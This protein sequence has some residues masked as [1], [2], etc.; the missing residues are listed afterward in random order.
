M[1]KKDYELIAEI[2]ADYEPLYIKEEE[3]KT[4]LVKQLAIAFK[5]DNPKFKKEL[6]LKACKIR[7]QE[8]K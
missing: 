8:T 4:E 5:N 2:F 7:T 6:F 3:A 1:L